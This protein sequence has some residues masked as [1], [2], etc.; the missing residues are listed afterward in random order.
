[1]SGGYDGGSLPYVDNDGRT[2]L[3]DSAI[4]QSKKYLESFVA[5]RPT[6]DL[7]PRPDDQG[8]MIIRPFVSRFPAGLK[9]E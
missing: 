3:K 2:V 8:N 7:P 6:G 5:R 1:M 4:R 9:A